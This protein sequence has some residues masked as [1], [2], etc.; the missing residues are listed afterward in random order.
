MYKDDKEFCD[1]FT[2]EDKRQVIEAMKA[3]NEM[4]IEIEDIDEEA[5]LEYYES[6]AFLEGEG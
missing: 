4:P 5:F 2:K 3:M 1:S 6:Y